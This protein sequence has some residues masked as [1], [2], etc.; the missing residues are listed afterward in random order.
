MHRELSL[1]VKNVLQL[2]ST[3]TFEQALGYFDRW[4]W[5]NE[6][7]KFMVNS[8]R[9]YEFW[10]YRWWLPLWDLEFVRFWRSLPYHLR[11][12]K[13]FENAYVRKLEANT[14][15]KPA[16]SDSSR[17]IVGPILVGILNRLHLRNMARRIRAHAE[18]NRHHFAW[19]GLIP[20]GDYH[21]A[22]HGQEDINT[23]LANQTVKQAFPQWKIPESL[24]FMA[25]RSEE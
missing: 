4:A 17:H 5:E 15:G 8:V 1:K 9:V 2:P 22:F 10:G 24:D 25:N 13:R 21:R 12:E 16:I 23:Y 6:K 18:Y 14:T 20:E 19:Y 11:F 3:L 7:A